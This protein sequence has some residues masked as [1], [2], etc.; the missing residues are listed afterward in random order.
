MILDIGGVTL[1]VIEDSM[2]G[3]LT[4]EIEGPY[5]FES[6]PFEKGDVV[7]DIGAHQGITSM[8][9]AK[10]F[11]GLRIYA[12]EPIPENF[13]RLLHN[14]EV[15]G[16]RNVKAYPW[17]VTADGRSFPILHGTHSAEGS[18]FFNPAVAYAAFPVKST[19]IPAILGRHHIKR[20]KLLKL[21]CEGA[22]HEILAD[23][24]GWMSRIDYVRGEIHMIP[25]LVTEGYTIEGTKARVPA[26]RAAWQVIENP[27][28][29]GL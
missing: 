12:Y 2:F 17:A 27:T 20:V 4:A 23:S 11:P 7:L 18:G 6:I 8:Y 1:D 9:L 28:L 19:S 3:Q 21:D 15:N 24:E 26:E 10:R 13:K 16:V 14:L 5:D 25:T 22:E 29:L